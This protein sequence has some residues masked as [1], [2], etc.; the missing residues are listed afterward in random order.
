[1]SCVKS[2]AEDEVLEEIIEEENE[3]EEEEEELEDQLIVSPEIY[4]F[5]LPTRIEATLT[6]ETSQ[7]EKF[8]N[9]LLGYNI[10][11]FN[12]Q[13]EKDFI[14]K[15]NPVSIRFPSGLWSNFYEWQTDGYQNDSWDNKSHEGALDIYAEKIKGHI[16]QIASL[17]TEKKE[18]YGRGFHMMWTYSMNFDDAESCLARAEKDAALGFEIKDIEL[19]NEHFWKSQRSNQVPTEYDYLTRASS[20][21]DALHQRFPEVRVSIPISWRRSHEA[22]N[23]VIIDDKKYFDAISL[24]KYMGSDPDVPGESNSAYSALLTSREVLAE[25]VNWIRSHAGDKPIWLTEWGV[26]ANSE[27]E[28]NS[29]ACLG[30]ADVYL[31][32]AENQDIYD[33]ANWFIFN[34]A[35]NPMVVVDERRKPIYPL[36]KRGYLSVYEIFQENFMDADVVASQIESTKIDGTMNAVNA[37]VVEKEGKKVVVAV[38]LA[39]K[40]A[41]FNLKMGGSDYEGSFTHHALVFDSLGAVPNIDIDAD[42]KRLI[43]E[44]D[45][46]ISL[47]P[48]SVNQIILQ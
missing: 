8:K 17:N 48:L 32:M 43:K 1:M 7:K 34:K 4:P 33:R 37:S 44:G 26:S 24:H 21:A 28:V 30:M 20:V 5:D 31:F 46:S 27:I 2:L 3:E 41:K 29:A 9:P 12:T 14:R 42:P 23:K 36:Q 10:E 16:N 39:N 25:D 35:L 22:Y 6:V 40:P 19:G 13:T 47:P 11:G 45:G 38:N 18:Q 15:F